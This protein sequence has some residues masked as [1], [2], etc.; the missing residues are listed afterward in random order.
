MAFI[1]N[2]NTLVLEKN[3]GSVR[4]V[5][6]GILAQNPVLTLHVDNKGERGLLG[7]AALKKIDNNNGDDISNN[8]DGVRSEVKPSSMT[9]VF[10]SLTEYQKATSTNKIYR[11]EW[12]GNSLRNPKLILNFLYSPDYITI[13]DMNAPKVYLCLFLL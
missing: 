11:F 10:L 2:N 7:M 5:F 3:T 13:C 12:D 1:D 8:L 4:L 6:D 9:Y